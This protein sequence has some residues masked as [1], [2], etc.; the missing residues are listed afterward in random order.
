MQQEFS[1]VLFKG[2]DCS[3]L[4]APSGEEFLFCFVCVC[5]SLDELLLHLGFLCSNVKKSS[6][7]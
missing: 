2:K 6:M 1:S 5:V 3:A 7:F 4:R